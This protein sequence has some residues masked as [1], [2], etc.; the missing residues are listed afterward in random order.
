MRIAF[1]IFLLCSNADALQK[2][3]LPVI[4]S[5]QNFTVAGF[6]ELPL[7]QK[8][9]KG[10]P[11]NVSVLEFSNGKWE[12]VGRIDLK[13]VFAIS[14]RFAYSFS[15]NTKSENSPLKVKASLYHCNKVTNKFCVIDDF[16]GEFKRSM[17]SSRAILPLDL[18]GTNP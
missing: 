2:L 7:G 3:K 9:N 16:E 15:V 13:T 4:T 6:I 18:K 1:V 5:L 8:L 12:T 17:K 14:E 10:A 11:S